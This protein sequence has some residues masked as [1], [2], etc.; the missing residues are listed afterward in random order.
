MKMKRLLAAVSV[1]ALLLGGCGEV[2]PTEGTT[3]PTMTEATE[4]PTTEGPTAPT[5]PITRCS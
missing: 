3:E 2:V 1:L 5:E 4:P